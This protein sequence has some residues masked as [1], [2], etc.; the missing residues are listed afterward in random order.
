MEHQQDLDDLKQQLSAGMR[1]QSD[2]RECGDVLLMFII[3]G[4]MSSLL[5]H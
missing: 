2:V 4:A 1:Q 3:Y 5:L